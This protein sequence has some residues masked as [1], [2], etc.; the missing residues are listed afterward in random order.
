MGTAVSIEA[1]GIDHRLEEPEP[2]LRAVLEHQPVVL[3]RVDAD[4][5]VLA[6]N[7]AGLSM[8]GAHALEQ[9]VGTSLM[10]VVASEGRNAC[11]EFIRRVV[12]GTRES[13]EA[14]VVGLT[15][16]RHTFELRASPHPG[17][18]DGIASALISFRDVTESRRL[19][20]S[21]V[22]AAAAQT[23][24]HAGWEAECRRLS[25]DL[26]FARARIEQLESEQVRLRESADAQL[27]ALQTASATALEVLRT[28]HDAE[29]AAGR[30]AADAALREF[31]NRYET[32]T[33]A[34]RNALNE[35]MADQA[36]LAHATSTAE[37]RL[38]ELEEAVR[39]AAAAE[40]AA[41]KALCAETESRTEAER[42]YRQMQTAI[43]R[44]VEEAGVS[45]RTGV[46]VPSAP[47][48]PA[49]TIRG[50]ASTLGTELP[51]RLGD[52]LELT[53]LATGADGTIAV[54]E[55]TILAAIGAFADSRR[56]S[57]LSGQV[58]AEISDVTID[59]AAGRQRGMSA[60]RYALVALHINGPG[61]QQGFPQTVFDS[62]DPRAWGEAKEELQAARTSIVDAGGQVWL[63]PEGASI[64]I[65]EF[66]LPQDGRR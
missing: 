34:L 4:G 48:T 64:V 41:Q 14:D 53:M 60:G 2:H 57:M 7:A 55:P 39:A 10:N 9:V 38:V 22:D 40:Q 54:D 59:D 6:I 30:E 47:A 27:S 11:L 43:A 62:A 65:V 49:T 24:Q 42:S 37:A 18:P 12:N 36:R 61:A 44:F 56:A 25:A 26:E 52:W 35:A 15:G 46:S 16:R 13:L 51:R 28:T 5:T 31:Q 32:D 33:G 50:L 23:E 29:Q 19:E 17:A 1:V 21:L 58:T 45:I 20:R 63:S 8:L 3:T 66:Y